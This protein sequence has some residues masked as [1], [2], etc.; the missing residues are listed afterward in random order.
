MRLIF[1]QM[2]A[3]EE[4]SRDESIVVTHDKKVVAYVERRFLNFQTACSVESHLLRYSVVSA[5]EMG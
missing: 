2:K 1:K 3:K 4:L 5:I